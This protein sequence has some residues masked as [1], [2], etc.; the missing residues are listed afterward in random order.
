MYEWALCMCGGR[1]L[2]MTMSL[3][4]L[5][6]GRRIHRRC[7][8]FSICETPS[9]SRPF[10]LPATNMW[11]RCD[12]NSFRRGKQGSITP[13][14][15]TTQNHTKAAVARRWRWYGWS[16]CRCPWPCGTGVFISLDRWKYIHRI[17]ISKVIKLVGRYSSCGL[18]LHVHQ[19]FR[20]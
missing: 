5:R 13:E 9:K 15:P 10:S 6:G 3:C 12:P 4:F 14:P 18:I 11:F 16:A 17:G 8:Y 7:I 1:P 2:A 19:T 20:L